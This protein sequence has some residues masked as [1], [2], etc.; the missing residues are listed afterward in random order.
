MTPFESIG[1]FVVVLSVVTFTA[2]V[3]YFCW[4]GVRL[5][6]QEMKAG[7]RRMVVGE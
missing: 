2:G 7:R 1:F 4:V 3:A 5:T 6:M